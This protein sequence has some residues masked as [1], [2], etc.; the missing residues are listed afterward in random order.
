M[1]NAHPHNYQDD[2]AKDTSS[3]DV[4]ANEGLPDYMD[5]TCAI[6]IS[7]MLNTT[8]HEITPASTKAAGLERKPHYSAKTKQ[9]YIVAAAEMWQYLE[10][11]FRKEDVSFPKAGRYKDETAFQAEFQSTIKPL[12][13]ARKGIV[14]FDK[15]FGFGG[16][17]HIDLFDG[18]TLSDAPDWYPSE[19]L[20]IWY[21]V[22]PTTSP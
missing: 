9:H 16:T 1:W 11:H 12:I 6:R 2:P 20:R 14:A 18:E 4:R 5:N 19:K 10:K 7:V 17:G 8:G 15:I 22:V 13:A 3:E 21:V